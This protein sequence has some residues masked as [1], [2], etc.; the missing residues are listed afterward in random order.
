MIAYT[1][2]EREEI[3]CA[4]FKHARKGKEQMIRAETDAKDASQ[5][6][7]RHSN[8]RG[9]R[10]DFV[11]TELQCPTV[12]PNYFW[13]PNLIIPCLPTKHFQTH[14]LRASRQP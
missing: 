12:Q 3:T 9:N 7:K 5:K 13:D 11:I 6:E 4:L 8:D 14:F 1:E 10:R 2:K